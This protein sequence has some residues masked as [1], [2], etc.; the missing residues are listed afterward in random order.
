V[1][2]ETGVV[3][4][5][6][7]QLQIRRIAVRTVAPAATHFALDDGMREGLQRFAALQW[8]AVEANL[9]LGRCLKHRIAGGVADVTTGTRDV[10]VVV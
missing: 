5:L 6:P 7:N 8:V 2:L 10:V 1:T 3:H 4:G 9:R